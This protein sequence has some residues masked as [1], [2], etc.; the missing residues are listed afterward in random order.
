MEVLAGEHSYSYTL[1]QRPLVGKVILFD[2]V[3]RFR[4]DA[5][6]LVREEGDTHLVS[7]F[8]QINPGDQWGD[9]CCSQIV[10]TC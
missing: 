2:P 5:H 10:L 3:C 6:G 1:D 8:S 9:R 4:R 7:Q